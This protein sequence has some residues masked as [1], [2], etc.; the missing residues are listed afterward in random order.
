MGRLLYTLSLQAI[1]HLGGITHIFTHP[2]VACVQIPA[3]TSV[4][5]TWVFSSCLIRCSSHMTIFANWE[6]GTETNMMLC[7]FALP[8]HATSL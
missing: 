7:G 3:N 8:D 4:K 6:K 1:V 2:L 5:K